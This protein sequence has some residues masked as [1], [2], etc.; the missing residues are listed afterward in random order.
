MGPDFGGAAHG[1]SDAEAGAEIGVGSE[2]S[3]GLAQVG[4]EIAAGFGGVEET[5][6]VACD[7]GAFGCGK[8]M[9]LDE[10]FVE[11]AGFLNRFEA[12]LEV[13]HVRWCSWFEQS[14]HGVCD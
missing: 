2:A 13:A 4:W 6:D 8:L 7:F 10:L 1:F 11:L 9:F 14:L 12:V 5:G 3:Q